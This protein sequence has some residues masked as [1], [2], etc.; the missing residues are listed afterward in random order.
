MLGPNFMRIACWNVNGLRSI[1][2]KGLGNVLE[3]TDPDIICLQETKITHDHQR[4]FSSYFESYRGDFSCAKR[5]GYSGVGTF[6]KKTLSL[7][8]DR[9]RPAIGVEFYDIEGRF[10]IT[11]Y[12]R[13]TLYN[14]Y[15]P[16]GTS[17]EE[18][19][20]FKYSFLDHF[21]G[22]LATLPQ[23]T[24][25]RLIVCGDFNICH[26]DIDIHHPKKATQLQ[27]SGFLP[28]ERQWIDRFIELGFID[29]FRYV[30]HDQGGIYSWWTYRA[31]ARGKNL[32]WRIDY[33]FVSQA[34]SPHIRNAEI[35]T[36]ILGSDHCP[37]LLDLDL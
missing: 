16:S 4:S 2:S 22:H 10:L 15:F 19:Q 28:E 23:S 18:R 27:L 29:S 7:S 32:G 26:R 25:D 33:I 36:E 17:G 21:Y 14:T 34:L 24:R 20:K 8:E 30:H 5:K 11:E 1:V 12:D 37:I 13:F 3:Q 35:R 31:G 9:I 6:S